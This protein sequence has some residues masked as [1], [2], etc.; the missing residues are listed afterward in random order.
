MLLAVSIVLAALIVSAA[1]YVSSSS[2]SD[3]LDKVRLASTQTQAT[4]PA[5]NTG[6]GT[7]A[8]TGTG[9]G[10][11]TGTAPQPT[12]PPT[13]TPIS[14]SLAGKTPAGA[15]DGSIIV[16][17][18]SDFQC[19][20]CERAVP[21]INQIESTYSDVSVYYKYFPLPASMHPQAQISA[22]AGECANMQGKFW[23]YH[24]LLFSNQQ[25][26]MPADLKKYAIT[27]GLDSAKFNDCLDSNAS[28]AVVSADQNEGNSIGVSGTPSFVIY[29]KDK[30]QSTFT[31]LAAYASALKTKY[32]GQIDAQIV[33]VNGAGYGVFF[34]GALPFEDFQAAIGAIKNAA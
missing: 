8:G 16:V 23:P 5:Q 14:I 20:Y 7:G 11:G 25:A 4:A 22:Q 3:A 33:E 13:S 24:D 27:A 21:V 12:T 1:V 31:A 15:A 26:L 32:S 19:P 9:T 10:S 30:K 34:S 6:A 2:I 28:A 29:A 18:Y 17:E